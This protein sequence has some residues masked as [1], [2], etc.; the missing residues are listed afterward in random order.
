[1][2]GPLT[3]AAVAAM[4][5]SKFEMQGAKLKKLFQGIRDSKKLSKKQREEWYMQ[6]RNLDIGCPSAL[7]HPMSKLGFI[8][9]LASIGPATIDRIGITRAATLAVGRCIK[10]LNSKHEFLNSNLEFKILLDGSLYAPRTYQNQ[11]TIIRG[12]EKINLIAAASI[13]AKVT[14]DRA[15]AR[16]AKKIPYYSFEIHKGYGTKKHRDAIS[17]NGFSRIHRRSFCKKIAIS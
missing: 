3:V 10:K 5:N 12:D 2:A 8:I 1:L 17:C 4:A 13:I 9:S 16:V 7:G 6:I 14:R 15:M 11:E